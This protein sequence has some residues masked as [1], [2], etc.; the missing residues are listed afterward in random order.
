MSSL[1]GIRE[2]DLSRNNLSGQIPKFLKTLALENLNLSFNDLDG[3]VPSKGVFANASALSNA[4]NNR[5]CEGITELQLPKCSNKGSKKKKVPRFIALI[6]TTSVILG[7]TMTS[8]FIFCWLKKGKRKQASE[9]MLKTTLLKLSYEMLLK[10]TNGFSPTHMVGT[11]SL[12]SVYKGILDNDGAIVAVKVLNLQHQG[13]SKSFMAEC[14]VLKNIRHRNLVRVITSCT[15]IDFQG[16][17]FKAIVYEFM[18]KGNLEQWLHLDSVPLIEEGQLETQNLSLLQRISIAIDVASAV[19]YLHHQCQRSI[20]HCDLKPSNVLLNSDMT[21]RV[22]DF[23][24]VR[25]LQVSNKNESSSVGVRGTIGYTPPEYGLGSEFSIHG[26][27]Y[28]NGILLLE[29]MTRKKPTDVMFE[30]DLNLHNFARTALPD[31]VMEIVDPILINE[32]VTASNHR[33]SQTGN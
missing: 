26:D 6:L 25:F 1:R 24:L 4:G 11:G 31:R 19:D 28:S 17:E 5:L 13:A 33:M 2:I 18:E 8:F 20:L 16:N 21:A 30:G 3:E 22:G 7:L 32:E 12:G 14:K 29:M 23:G 9:P 10:A 15:S 27:V